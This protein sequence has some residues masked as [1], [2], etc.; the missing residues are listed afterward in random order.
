MDPTTERVR[1]PRR[2]RH[3]PD[4]SERW[5]R[6]LFL[7]AGRD[8]RMDGDELH[9]LAMGL[10]RRDEVAARLVRA[11]RDDR[12]VSMPQFHTA[13]SEGVA[14]V[15]DGPAPLQTFFEHVE[16]RPG[17]V[18]DALLD[19]GA[20]AVRRMGPDAFEILAYGSLLG[21]YRTGGPLQPLVRTGRIG[22]RNTLRRV[23]ET[24]QWFLGCIDP[25]GLDRFGPGW[26]LSVHV[27][28]MHA[29]VNHQLERDPDWDWEFRGV[30]IN[31]HDRA[32][33]I[34]SFST[35]FLVHARMLGLRVSEDDSTAIMHLWSYVGWLMGVEE[36]WLPH[37]ER[38]G[39]R[40]LANI[41]AGAS[42]PEDASTQL[43]D[44]LMSMYDAAPGL[45]PRGRRYYH[46]RGRSIATYLHTRRGMRDVG[47]QPGM[48][49][50]PVLRIAANLCWTQVVARLPDGG[51]HLDRRAER[52]L[53]RQERVQYDGTRPPIADAAA[54]ADVL[55]QS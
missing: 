52:A 53:Q 30:P 17:W 28:L 2:W 10:W 9:D 12:T 8:A 11:I 27:R 49:W 32:G 48:P 36:R 54:S 22:G 1:P 37:T 31:Q 18:D 21:G 23:G 40:V 45:G 3:D 55:K 7:L 20:Q 16:D 6:P 35:S 13:L 42:G 34:G 26:R 15:P 29:L 38:I 51:R 4:W 24:G 19:R 41:L 14:A 47:Q 25:G 50:Y 46:A 33:T 44:G 5:A 39:R 43:G